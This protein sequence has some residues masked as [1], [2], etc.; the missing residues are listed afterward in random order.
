M[1]ANMS[2]STGLQSGF[3]LTLAPNLPGGMIHRAAA[4][5]QAL[6]RPRG[7]SASRRRIGLRRGAR[8]GGNTGRAIWGPMQLA[9]WHRIFI[10][11]HVPSR[12]EDPL[13]WTA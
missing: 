7:S 4:P 2:F 10:E 6:P 11:G 13:A 12:D 8:W 9:I 3:V 1:T 5:P